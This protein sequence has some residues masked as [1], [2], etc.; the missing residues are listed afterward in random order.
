MRKKFA[1]KAKF[2][3][4]TKHALAALSDRPC[5]PVRHA[6]QLPSSRQTPYNRASD[7]L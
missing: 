5:R 1:S 7:E 6:N 2:D 4:Y 3:R